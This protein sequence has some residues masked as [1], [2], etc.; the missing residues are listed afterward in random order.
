MLLFLGVQS[1]AIIPCRHRTCG[2]NT[3]NCRNSEKTDD[4]EGKK[5]PSFVY[6]KALPVV[7]MAFCGQGKYYALQI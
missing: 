3:D 4:R 7:Q 2:K 5:S 6:T 1:N